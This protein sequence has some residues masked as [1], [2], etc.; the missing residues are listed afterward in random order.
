MTKSMTER[1]ANISGK[2]KHSLDANRAD[3]NS[4]NKQRRNAATVR[5]LKMYK[6]CLRRSAM[7]ML[8]EE[9][10]RMDLGTWFAIHCL[11]RDKVVDSSD[12]VVQVLDARDPQG[13][14][15][16]PIREAFERAWQE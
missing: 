7:I 11:R 9:V 13:N 14:K 6:M 5:R 2:P 1:R 10:K 3:G 12:V 4:K 16:L 8:Q 15:M